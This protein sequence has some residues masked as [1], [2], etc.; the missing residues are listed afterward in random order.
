PVRGDV[1]HVALPV[2]IGARRSWSARG[3][4]PPGHLVRAALGLDLPGVVPAR[5]DDPARARLYARALR[6]GRL[7]ADVPA[8]SGDLPRAR[9]RERA[10]ARG[11]LAAVRS[12]E[13]TSELQSR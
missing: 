9:A 11:G 3:G 6:A 13:H 4:E 5:L 2:G 8:G 7:R 12:E 1:A 10:R